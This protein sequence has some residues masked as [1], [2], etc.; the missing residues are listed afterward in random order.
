MNYSPAIL[1]LQQEY[2][3][4]LV[5]AIKQRIDAMEPMEFYRWLCD[6]TLNDARKVANAARKEQEKQA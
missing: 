6:R 1:A 4:D 3:A 2:A 5:P